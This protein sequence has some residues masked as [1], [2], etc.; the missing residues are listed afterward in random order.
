MAHMVFEDFGGLAIKN[1]TGDCKRCGE[2][3]PTNWCFEDFF[4]TGESLEAF[5][6][7]VRQCS[8]S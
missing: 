7:E 8:G 1:V 4:P 6:E 3:Q 5:E 2:V